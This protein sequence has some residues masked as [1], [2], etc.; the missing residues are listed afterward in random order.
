MQYSPSCRNEGNFSSEASRI[1]GYYC[2]PPKMNIELWPWMRS[3]FVSG[4]PPISISDRALDDWMRATVGHAGAQTLV[5]DR[6]QRLLH[7]I[8]RHQYYKWRTT[9]GSLQFA[10]SVIVEA[11]TVSV[12][13][14]NP[15][16]VLCQCP[17]VK[18]LMAGTFR[19]NL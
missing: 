12:C 7:H 8:R 16:G 11:R 4:S 19:T 1:V 18:C 3:L 17:Y 5:P 14:F 2:H 13:K 10:S 15:L 9:G 6:A